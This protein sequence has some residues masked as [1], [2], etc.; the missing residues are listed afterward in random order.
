[1]SKRKDELRALLM[2]GPAASPAPTA[3]PA[4]AP[5]AAS[6]S[7][8][9]ST[10]PSA[11][12]TPSPSRSPSRTAA[13]A[14]REAAEPTGGPSASE[15]RAPEVRGGETPPGLD[16]PGG[17]DHAGN[18]RE[19]AG[20]D[21]IQ[22][23]GSAISPG[24]PAA[25]SPGAA[26][27]EPKPLPERTTSGAVKAM[28]L[29]L[30][31]LRSGAEEARALRESIA[32]GD[33]VVELDPARIEPAF[34]ADRLS[35]GGE[36]DESFESLKASISES[37]Q[38]V[39]I[40]VR[41]HPDPAKA[42][43]GHYQAAYG[44]RRIS[45]TQALGLKVRAVVRP[46]TDEELVLAQGK[47]NSERR[48]LSFIERALFCRALLER[49]FERRTV[50]SAL[51]L[52]KAEL[53]RLLQVADLIPHH[54]A[55]AI[56]PAPRAG[57]P[58]WMTLAERIGADAANRQKAEDEIGRDRFRLASSDDRFALVWARLARPSAAAA[59]EA[60]L[61]PDGARIGALRR[62][63]KGAV[64]EIGEADFA[65]FLAGRIPELHAAFAAA[66]TDGPQE[67]REIDG[68]RDKKP[69]RR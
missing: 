14:D 36:G 48:D 5:S 20:P 34:V 65:A 49:G 24:A 32:R 25:S 16:G 28:G 35:R 56:G 4:P 51:S 60:L 1:M 52:H 7:T 26:L 43:A 11:T 47:E 21:A 8:T 33:Q 13:R 15:G 31:S 68:A 61:S 53:T 63:G 57:R 62:S 27:P 10:T 46:L 3:K 37:G 30:G 19:D 50:Q 66:R 69:R 6:P 67:E 58:R 18:G 12:A 59:E 41:P 44:H 2:G 38:T 40:L 17:G 55:A 42:K 23:T 64:I 45:A 9:Q 39:P 54:I 22:A 29:A